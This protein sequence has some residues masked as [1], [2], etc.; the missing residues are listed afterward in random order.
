MENA[1][2]KSIY[3]WMRLL[4]RDIGFFAIGLT[5]IYC[6]SGIMLTYRDTDFLKSETQIEKSTEPGL[7][8]NQLGRVLHL[9]SL[10]VINEN[11]KEI[12][13]TDG[14]YNKETGVASY[15]SKELPALLRAFNSLHF[16]SSQDSRHWFTA[17]YAISLLFLAISSF[18]MYKPGSK[19]FKRGIIISISGV[20]FSILLMLI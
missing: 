6:I 2:R 12:S 20:V 10:N 5:V 13:F 18:W 19:H 16:V 4:H 15:T 11:E 3:S 1:K 17:L 14:T 9:K 7:S 8:A